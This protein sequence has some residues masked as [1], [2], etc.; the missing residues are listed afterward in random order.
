LVQNLITDSFD[1]NSV[2]NLLNP[3][4]LEELRRAKVTCAKR[5]LRMQM[6]SSSSPIRP[7]NRAERANRKVGK[8]LA[9]TWDWGHQIRKLL[10][11]TQSKYR[12]HGPRGSFVPICCAGS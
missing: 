1:A 9:R 3:A 6:P 5:E 11:N 8:R 4:F 10:S 2:S 12:P 7:F